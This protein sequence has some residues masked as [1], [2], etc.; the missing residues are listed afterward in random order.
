MCVEA[1]KNPRFSVNERTDPNLQ[2]LGLWP[3]VYYAATT[4]CFVTG[5]GTTR[6]VTP[7]TYPMVLDTGAF[8]SVIPQRWLPLLTGFVRLSGSPI[9]FSTASGS[10]LGAMAPGTR[11]LFTT[12][13]CRDY[14]IDFLATPP[15]DSRN[16]G[17]FSLRDI[18]RLFSLG[19]KG[20]YLLAPD[21]RPLVLPTIELL[22]R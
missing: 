21:G 1:G 14:E 18:V 13:P 3:Y 15:L 6:R 17:L 5:T 9:P 2:A 12:D 4:I 10:G 22:P 16:H 8:V 7:T 20:P 19:T 11:F